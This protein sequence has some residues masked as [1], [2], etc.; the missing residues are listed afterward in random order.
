MNLLNGVYFRTAFPLEGQAL[1]RN[2]YNDGNFFL[3]TAVSVN[4][5]SRS[6]YDDAKLL[7][8]CR[9][10]D[11]A[12][13]EQLVLRHQGMLLNIAFRISGVYEDACDIVQDSFIVAWQ[14]IGDFRGEAK[15]STW[16]TAI[17]VN[18]SRTRR[19]RTRQSA[20]REAYSLNA[21]L[22]GHDGDSLPEMA[23]A[24]RSALDQLEE[25]ELRMFLQRCIAALP[26][27]F[28]EVLV[29]R[30]MQELSY[31]EVAGALKLKEGTVKSRLFRGRDAVKECMKRAVGKI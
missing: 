9:N 25:T 8:A 29:L 4:M 23:S 31:D 26:Q 10:G 2:L 3:S 18:N 17:V 5:A 7:K 30:D 22:P 19:Q 13:F 28:R 1:W 21:P 27:E 20:A 16:L 15:L 14:K 6:E 12:A 11:L 24:S